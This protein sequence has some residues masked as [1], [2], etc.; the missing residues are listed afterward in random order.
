MPYTAHR[1]LSTMMIN[2]NNI[3]TVMR[4]SVKAKLPE[5]VTRLFV[6][7]VVLKRETIFM[8]PFKLRGRTE[9]RNRNYLLFPCA[10]VNLFM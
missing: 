6:T 2:K 9:V 7:A 8:I 4:L 1:F 3:E 5:I 10:I